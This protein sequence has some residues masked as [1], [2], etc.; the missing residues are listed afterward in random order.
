M[1]VMTVDQRRS[2]RGPDLVEELLA[3]Y[4]GDARLLRPFERTAGD[5]VQAV[6]TDPDAVVDLTLALVRDGHWRVGVGAGP[7][8]E[9]LPASTRA[10]SGPAFF[11][12][13][14]A[15]TRAKQSPDQV[16]VTGPDPASAARAE[17][18][19]GLLA[20]LVQ[21]RSAAGWEA[22]ELL[23]TGLN[24][25]E[26]AERLRISPQAVNDR[27]RAALYVQETGVRPVAAHLL[28][29]ADT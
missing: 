23:R 14:D 28:T 19:L 8:A 9:P 26:A 10:G 20:T 15:V 2:R 3:G 29:E 7:V 16:A 4:A 5:E 1:F 24:Q 13:R 22:V 25:S 27:L 11:H 17:A 18:V 12:A 21:R 6:L